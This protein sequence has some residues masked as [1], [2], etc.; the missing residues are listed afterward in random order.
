ML[1]GEVNIA[2]DRAPMFFKALG[3]YAKYFFGIAV[4]LVLPL[5]RR[6]GCIVE[7]VIVADESLVKYLCDL[8]VGHAGLDDDLAGVCLKL[9]CD[10]S[11]CENGRGDADHRE[12]HHD[13]K[14]RSHKALQ[15]T[16]FHAFL[17]IK[18]ML[19]LVAES[20]RKITNFDRMTT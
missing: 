17:H 3:R 19:I 10:C 5:Q 6:L 4:A 12:D 14:Q 13:C 11:L 9:G 16:I 15:I 1:F 20:Y 7:L 8:I 2:V 18:I